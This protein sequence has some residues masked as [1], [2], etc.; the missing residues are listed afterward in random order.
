MLVSGRVYEDKKIHPNGEPNA[1][2]KYKY[3]LL[4]MDFLMIYN[5]L[6]NSSFM[7]VYGPSDVPSIRS[8]TASIEKITG[9]RQQPV[10]K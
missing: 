3:H 9:F 7:S 1:S 2:I 6:N 10:T 4:A 5:K 8:S